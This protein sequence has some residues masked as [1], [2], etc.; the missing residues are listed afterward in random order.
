MDISP[1]YQLIEAALS[2][3]LGFALGIVYDLFR[4]A[5]R[6]LNALHLTALFDAL[7][8]VLAAA[9][10][11]FF[12]A[13]A[14]QR[15][16][17]LFMFAFAFL[18]GAFY[19]LTLSAPAMWL[20]E[21]F[22]DLIQFMFRCLCL[23]FVISVKFINFFKETLKRVFKYLKKWFRISTKRF[24]PSGR[25]DARSRYTKEERFENEEGKYYYE[26]GRTHRNRLRGGDADFA[27]RENRSS[28]I[29]KTGAN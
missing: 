21:K 20:L 28:R 26:A 18:G 2:V 25:F 12:G 16:F 4:I 17:R 29:G 13:G 27:Q 8:W 23:P 24:I 7:Y 11:F 9:C 1:S 10:L 15:G 22:A 5:R 19:F 6:R 14:S 3:G